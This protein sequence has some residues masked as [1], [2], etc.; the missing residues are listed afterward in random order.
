MDRV[1]VQ[2]HIASALAKYD[3]PVEESL[4][5]LA[6]LEVDRAES[7]K[8]GMVGFRKG[9][10]RVAIRVG[11]FVRQFF[12]EGMDDQTIQNIGADITALLWSGDEG[13]EDDGLNGV[14]ELAGEDLRRFYLA[15]VSGISSCMA[16]EYTQE[17]L[18]IYVDNPDV[19]KLATV[20][21]DDRA[22]RALV[23]TFP[24]GRRYMDRI[25]HTSSACCSALENYAGR[26]G[27][28]PRHDIPST[29]VR[30]KIRNG[31]DSY[32]PYLD[33]LRYMDII[34]GNTC[35]LSTGS[36]D[37]CLQRTDGYLEDHGEVC[38]ACGDGIDEGEACVGTDEQSYCESCYDERFFICYRCGLT[39]SVDNAVMTH[40][41]MRICPTCYETH[42]FTCEECDEV[43]HHVSSVLVGG[44]DRTVCNDCFEDE[45]FRCDDCEEDFHVDEK[46]AGPGGTSVCPE[47]AEQYAECAECGEV[48]EKDALVDGMC[49]DC[50]TDELVE[51]TTTEEVN[52]A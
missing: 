29:R 39:E 40:E 5:R 30:M 25:Y 16:H 36:G 50:A 4:K 28:W 46:H 35:E 21:I 43:Y 8:A 10:K 45:Y 52:H 51:V 47:C 22:A 48:F 37:Y 19:V 33:T 17:F 32:W 42:Y 9:D 18:D 49:S 11:K 26:K 15:G 3:R 24:D 38:Y 7:N 20:R 23:W 1:T 2:G 14:R 44:C 41:G 13:E 27:I 34:D 31:E 12:G 6:E